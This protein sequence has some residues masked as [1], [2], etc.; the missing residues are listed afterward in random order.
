MEVDRA[1]VPPI[2]LFGFAQRRNPKRG[3]LFVSRVLGRH[4]PVAPSAMQSS[5]DALARQC[6]MTGNKPILVIGMAE[7]AVGLGAGVHRELVRRN[8]DR[9]VVYLTTTRHRLDA[10]LLATFEEEHSHATTH[11]IHEPADPEIMA[12]VR[13][14]RSLVLVDDEMSTGKTFINLV[15]ALRTSGITAEDV[16]LVTLTDWSDGKAVAA[17]GRGCRSVS[18]LSGRYSWTPDAKAPAIEMPHVD[19]TGA[20]AARI[21]PAK[22]WGRL[23]VL[24]HRDVPSEFARCRPGERILV[25]GTGEHVWRPFL[26]AEALEKNGAHVRYSSVTRSPIAVG[27][28]IGSALAFSDNY[29]LGIANFAYNVDPALYDRII[30][31]VETTADTI[32]PT[33]IEAISPEIV[34]D[35]DGVS[36]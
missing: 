19:V 9:T 31:C 13:E 16:S 35:I 1:A 29:G 8:P 33:L 6:V 27:H 4:I 23:G 22:D 30:L 5:Y 17:I 25:L 20:G 18:L 2:D 15:A 11:L 26:L 34:S 3:F 36:P 7:T 32:D 24:S 28:A 12:A 10:P 21:D 14:A